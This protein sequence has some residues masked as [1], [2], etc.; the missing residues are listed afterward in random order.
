M[1]AEDKNNISQ[2][3]NVHANGQ[4]LPWIQCALLEQTIRK[5]YG[6]K[7]ALCVCKFGMKNE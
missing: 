6:T 1:Q 7:A 5:V 3:V 4:P 2:N